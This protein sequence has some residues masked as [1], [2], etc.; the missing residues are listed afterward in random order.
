MK[1]GRT[2]SRSRMFPRIKGCHCLKWIDCR[3]SPSIE[4]V[5]TLSLKAKILTR[6]N[7]KYRSRICVTIMGTRQILTTSGIIREELLLVIPGTELTSLV[8]FSFF[9]NKVPSKGTQSYLSL[10]TQFH[11]T[12]VPIENRHYWETNRIPTPSPKLWPQS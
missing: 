9:Q 8:S 6:P 3:D 1:T 10:M 11:Q 5:W 12:E 4:T 7:F 2:R